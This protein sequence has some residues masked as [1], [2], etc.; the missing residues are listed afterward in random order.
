MHI[1]REKEK[2]SVIKRTA[3]TSD[4][5]DDDDGDNDDSI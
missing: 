4:D 2:W 3:M 1:L 5:D